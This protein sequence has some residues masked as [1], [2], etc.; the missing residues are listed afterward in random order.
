MLTQSPAISGAPLSNLCKRF[1][2]KVVFPPYWGGLSRS[3]SQ[4]VEGDITG[5]V[6]WLFFFNQYLVPEQAAVVYQAMESPA[7]GIFYAQC[8]SVAVVPSPGLT[9][10]DIFLCDIPRIS[11]ASQSRVPSP[12]HS[13]HVV[14]CPVEDHS[15]GLVITAQD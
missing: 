7:N 9:Y 10:S 3:L 13:A 12:C 15:R 6:Y 1:G 14:S 2:T 5:L 11:C 4:K 8:R